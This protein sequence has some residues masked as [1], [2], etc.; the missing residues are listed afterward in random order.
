MRWRILQWLPSFGLSR[1]QRSRGPAASVEHG[2][3]MRDHAGARVRPTD[4]R[5]GRRSGISEKGP[6]DVPEGL[7]RAIGSLIV[8]LGHEAFSVNR[9]QARIRLSLSF[10][11]QPLDVS[12]R[13]RE[14]GE[15]G[16]TA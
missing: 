7:A 8:T 4:R 12:G 1:T 16:L 9:P 10:R 14:G 5:V 3:S 13:R 11:H 2:T 6:R 15:R